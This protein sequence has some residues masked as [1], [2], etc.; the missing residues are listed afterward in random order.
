ML[1]HRRVCRDMEHDLGFRIG[2]GHQSYQFDTLPIACSSVS[3][4]EPGD[5]VFY[6]A[7]CA[8]AAAVRGSRAFC[9]CQT[10]PTQLLISSVST[11]Q[12]PS[13]RFR[14]NKES[15]RGCKEHDMV[16]VEVYLGEVTVRHGRSAR[17]AFGRRDVSQGVRSVGSRSTDPLSEKRV[18]V[19][20]DYRFDR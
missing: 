11:G 12:D 17:S 6:S 5:L 9:G 20:D 16:H 4:L 19:H 1:R 18:L 3:E 8:S 10:G 7:T 15:M 13:G 14:Y 2:P